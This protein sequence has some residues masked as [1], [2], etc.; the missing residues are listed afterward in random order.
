[1]KRRRELLTDHAKAPMSETNLS[2][3]DELAHESKEQK[4]T[5]PARKRFFCHLTR[6][7]CFPEREKRPFS[8]ILTA[9]KSCSGID[10]RIAIESAEC[11]LMS[12]P[13]IRSVA[14]DVQRNWTAWTNLSS[15]GKL[16]STTVWI[17]LP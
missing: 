17:S 1:M 5:A 10:R 7:L 13:T 9:G 11:Q 2:S 15:W 8:M 16:T 14:A 3:S 4:M 6:G 12:V